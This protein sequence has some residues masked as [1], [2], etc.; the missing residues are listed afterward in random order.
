[1]RMMLMMI[2]KHWRLAAHR[3]P[4]S[5]WHI[6]QLNTDWCALHWAT[7]RWVHFI[8]GLLCIV[9]VHQIGAALVNKIQFGSARSQNSQLCVRLG[10]ST[11]CISFSGPYEFVLGRRRHASIRRGPAATCGKCECVCLSSSLSSSS[12]ATRNKINFQAMKTRTMIN[13][14]QH[15]QRTRDW[16]SEAKNEQENIGNHIKIF[17]PS[18]IMSLAKYR[19]ENWLPHARRHDGAAAAAINTLHVWLMHCVRSTRSGTC[20]FSKTLTRSTR[21]R[22]DRLATFVHWWYF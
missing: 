16:R 10:V 2:H 14:L 8:S 13:N 4:N 6:T 17:T 15:K 18:H 12:C 3:G 11:K 5:K 1:M 7:G 20:F 9:I 22:Y 19:T 21:M